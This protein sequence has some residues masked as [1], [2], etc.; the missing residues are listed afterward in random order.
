MRSAAVTQAFVP[1]E[2]AEN[3]RPPTYNICLPV[4][5][6]NN[7]VGYYFNHVPGPTHLYCH[8]HSCLPQIA[9]SV[10]ITAM[11]CAI[12]GAQLY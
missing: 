1:V 12:V 6:C 9:E 8:Q 3:I 5:K 2:D 7:N 4:V 11:M 10:I